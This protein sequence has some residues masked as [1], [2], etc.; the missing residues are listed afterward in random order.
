MTTISTMYENYL[1]D[2]RKFLRQVDQWESVIGR[3]KNSSH[4]AKIGTKWVRFIAVQ[5]LLESQELTELPL[6]ASR[7]FNPMKKDNCNIP[8]YFQF[9]RIIGCK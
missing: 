4:T 6:N 8:I 2:W 7:I 5:L 1:N 9:G 3:V